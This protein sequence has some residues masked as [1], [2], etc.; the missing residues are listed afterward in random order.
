MSNNNNKLTATRAK[1]Q[2]RT[3]NNKCNRFIKRSHP[4]VTVQSTQV[5][6]C[7]ALHHFDL[8]NSIEKIKKTFDL[9][10]RRKKRHLLAY[11]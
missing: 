3:E 7:T 2:K 11:K 9:P 8:L 5:F 10:F 1:Q 6:V 4:S